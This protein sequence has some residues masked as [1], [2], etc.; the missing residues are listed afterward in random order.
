MSIDELA[1][2]ADMMEDIDTDVSEFVRKLAELQTHIE[3]LRAIELTSRS[4]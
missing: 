2:L 1:S 3:E 4:E